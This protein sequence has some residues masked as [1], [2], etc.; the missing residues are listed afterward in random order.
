M[1]DTEKIRVWERILTLRENILSERKNVYV[2]IIILHNVWDTHREREY[3]SEREFMCRREKNEWMTEKG[4]R[5]V[6]ECETG[7]MCLRERLYVKERENICMWERL[8]NL[9]STFFMKSHY[10]NLND[11]FLSWMAIIFIWSSFFNMKFIF[12]YTKFNF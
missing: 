11:T 5:K 7:K 9:K 2:P 6:R 12:F 8:F 10:F 4:K 3:V 1:S